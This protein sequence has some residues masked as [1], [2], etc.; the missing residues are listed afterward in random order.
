MYIVYTTPECEEQIVVKKDDLRFPIN[1]NTYVESYR[2]LLDIPHLKIKYKTYDMM[3]AAS[4]DEAKFP[5]CPRNISEHE[6][7]L[8]L[9]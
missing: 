7:Y 9:F 3:N 5:R 2:E 8:S 4:L 6:E 1:E